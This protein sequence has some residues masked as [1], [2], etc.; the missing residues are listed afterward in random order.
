[1]DKSTITGKFIL[2]RLQ[3]NL[4]RSSFLKKVG[5]KKKDMQ[6]FLEENGRYVLYLDRWDPPSNTYIWTSRG[7]THSYPVDDFLAAAI[8]EGKS[9]WDVEAEI[10]WVDD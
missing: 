10:E 1:M 4:Q 3:R 7:D 9:F 5:M 8:W 6:G 2:K